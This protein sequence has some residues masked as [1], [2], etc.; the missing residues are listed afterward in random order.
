[1]F[2]GFLFGENMVVVGKILSSWGVRGEAKVLPL[3]YSNDR[4]D[5]LEQVYISEAGG[6]RTLTI[7]NYRVAGRYI[8]IKFREVSTREDVKKIQGRELLIREEQSPPLPEG[9]YYH[10]QIIG[11]DVFTEEGECIGRITNIIETGSN[12]VYV[13]EG[14]KEILIP[15][16]DE[17]IKEIDVN[18]K[19]MII[20][21][22]EGLLDL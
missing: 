13:V 5:E 11:L 10:Y 20:H 1:M 15:A 12:D 7:E 19:K 14:E 16:I 18:G 17:V 3:T 4:F 6:Y 21:L 8:I 9:V 22:I 2:P